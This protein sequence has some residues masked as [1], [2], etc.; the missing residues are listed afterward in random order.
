M[1][2]SN[3][4]KRR[5]VI[6]HGNIGMKDIRKSIKLTIIAKRRVSPRQAG[7]ME[8]SIKLELVVFKCFWF[9]IVSRPGKFIG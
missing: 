8:I 4:T 5:Q 1:K 3:S 2:T 7:D 9:E 6:E